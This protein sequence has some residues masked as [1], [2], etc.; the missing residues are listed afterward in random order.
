[1]TAAGTLVFV[2]DFDRRVEQFPY[3][4]ALRELYIEVAQL[5]QWVILC[6][7][8]LGLGSLITPATNDTELSHLL[9]L[10]GSTSP[11]Y[12]LTFGRR[13]RQ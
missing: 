5:A 3:E 10:D 7:E 8:S 13:A 11:I 1:M 12:T 6:A 9:R 4:R 2:V